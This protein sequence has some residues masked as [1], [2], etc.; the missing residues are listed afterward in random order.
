MPIL[1]I[2][3]IDQL[4]SFIDSSIASGRHNNASE[5]VREGLR[6]LEERHKEEGAKLE[7]LREDAR[8]GFDALDRGD[9]IEI[10]DE[11]ALDEAMQQIDR[12]AYLRG[13]LARID[14]ATARHT[15]EEN[16]AID[17]LLAERGAE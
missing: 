4:A 5:V 2:D 15:P 7:R 17:R 12:K 11:A 13:V 8:I 16:A 6:L 14:A 9:Y 1:N 3:L 10:R